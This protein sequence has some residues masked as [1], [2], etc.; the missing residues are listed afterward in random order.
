MLDVS[1]RWGM[2]GRQFLDIDRDRS[3]AILEMVDEGWRLGSTLPSAHAGAGEVEITECLREGMRAALGERSTDYRFRQMTVLAGTESR[4]SGEVLRP[5]GRTDLP[6]LFSDLREKYNAHD[7]HAIVECKRV[8]GNRTGLCREYVREGID[9]F[10]TG[11]YARNH[12][13]GFMVGYLLS[14]DPAAAAACINAH[15]SRKRRQS[16][17]LGP[18][19]FARRPWAR[20]SRHPR[21][22]PAEPIALHHGFLGLPPAPP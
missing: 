1:S 10:A 19:V 9:R 5:D 15:L 18:C 11:K 12:A 16:E 4:S 20:S 7:P 2:V 6:V 22:A 17:H 13:V 8:A 14:G 3:E 21:A